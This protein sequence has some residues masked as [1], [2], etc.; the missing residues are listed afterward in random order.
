MLDRNKSKVRKLI[1]GVSIGAVGHSQMASA[2]PDPRKTLP[3]GILKAIY[4]TGEL[5]GSVVLGDHEKDKLFYVGPS[6]KKIE[7]GNFRY[8]DY[9]KNCGT[10][11]KMFRMAY[12]VPDVA[13]DQFAEVS[14]RGSYSPFFDSH[15]GNS[16]VYQD[17]LRKLIVA[18]G[19]EETLK[20]EHA[21]LFTAYESAKKEFEL[22]SQAVIQ[23]KSAVNELNEN[24]KNAASLLALATTPDEKTSAEKALEDARLQRDT[25]LPEY[26]Q[27]WSDALK[28]EVRVRP[29]YVEAHGRVAPYLINLND[30]LSRK[31]SL[32]KI[33]ED[34]NTV[35]YNAYVRL[36]STLA[37]FKSRAVGLATASYSVWSDE[38]AT[39]SKK[40]SDIGIKD[41]MVVPLP[42]LNIRLE[43]GL[44]ESLTKTANGLGED[45]VEEFN[46]VSKRPGDGTI[47]IADSKEP[48]DKPVFKD[49]K[50]NPVRTLVSTAENNSAGVYAFPISQ[51]A[52]CMGQSEPKL[53]AY[54]PKNLLDG[55][56]MII[57]REY[58]EREDSKFSQAIALNYDYYVKAEPINV[59]CE[60]K[61]AQVN[62]YLR[63]TG[64]SGF[65]FWRK[66]WD[67][68]ERKLIKD[69]GISCHVEDS[70]NMLDE[71]QKV[72]WKNQVIA[73][74]SQ[75]IMAE[76][77]VQFAQKWDI[78][79]KQP[80]KVPEASYSGMGN[81]S[82][83]CGANY[84]CQIGNIVWK[85][86]DA[87]FGRQA[88]ST[89]T[90]DILEGKIY[91]KY[92]ES[93]YRLAPGSSKVE[94]VVEVK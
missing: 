69:S 35:S 44:S 76:Y 62:S 8:L 77:T 74:M 89:S 31:D 94:L 15:F 36:E 49:E 57:S 1:L 24:V 81:M 56:V 3:V 21:E 37:K 55:A 71:E 9:A 84:Y 67:D 4:E 88:G 64:S 27:R 79:E 50:G 42:L 29:K 80:I 91:R 93:G 40:L 48:T 63:N 60:L 38:V 54:N 65:L 22:A 16:I 87:L 26:K 90:R 19:N 20:A 46:V 41:A 30:V 53:K 25:H 75:E 66:S 11:E 83:L 10:L 28:E 82:L 58:R 33:Y 32:S 51:A 45:I 12:A 6:Q 13:E 59:S 72:K 43:T 17:I 47:E 7:T 78:L 52:Y 85:S 2:L 5:N 68:T 39:L 34:I 23:A 61:L 92:S 73:S 70:P 18:I 14:K 86:A